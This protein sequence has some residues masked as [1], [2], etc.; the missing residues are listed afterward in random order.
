MKIKIPFKNKFLISTIFVGLIYNLI[1]TKILYQKIFSLVDSD[2]WATIII[3]KYGG[4]RS[5]GWIQK[6]LNNFSN[7]PEQFAYFLINIFFILSIILS[8]QIINSFETIKRNVTFKYIGIIYLSTTL[9]S[10]LASR[11]VINIRWTLSSLIYL[12]FIIKL[13][14]YLKFYCNDNFFIKR[15]LGEQESY[16]IDNYPNKYISL[17][18]IIISVVFF[19][20]IHPFSI[21]YLLSL[22]TILIIRTSVFFKQKYYVG[23]FILFSI[24][25]FAFLILSIFS[26]IVDYLTNYRIEGYQEYLLIGITFGIHLAYLI[27]NKF[28]YWIKNNYPWAKLLIMST[29]LGFIIPIPFMLTRIYVP[30]LVFIPIIFATFLDKI[31]LSRNKSF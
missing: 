27:N 5:S 18:S 23:I 14:E 30:Y 8:Y 1:F 25:G 10:V 7:S 29:M 6:I 20:S 3:L 21:Y 28:R 4:L 16:N 11:S 12:I 22:S 17:L 31:V 26:N 13:Y 15:I 24:F 2:F 19:L 9:N